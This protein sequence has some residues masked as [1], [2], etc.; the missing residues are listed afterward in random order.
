M[1]MYSK[2]TFLNAQLS[3]ECVEVIKANTFFVELAGDGSESGDE[4]GDVLVGPLSLSGAAG[5][6]RWSGSPL[7]CNV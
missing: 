6:I 7:H 3:V 5:Q 4:H 1:M 2:C